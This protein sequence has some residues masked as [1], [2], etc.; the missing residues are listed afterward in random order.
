MEYTMEEENCYCL[1]IK[2]TESV[3]DKHNP[4]VFRKKWRFSVPDGFMLYD[5]NEVEIGKSVAFDFD[6]APKRLP[7]R[8]KGAYRNKQG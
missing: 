7:L 4:S 3:D 5:E 8:V 1:N 6:K 2:Q